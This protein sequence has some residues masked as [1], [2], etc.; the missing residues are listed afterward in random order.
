MGFLLFTKTEVSHSRIGIPVWKIS[1]VESIGKTFKRWNMNKDE[2]SSVRHDSRLDDDG[3]FLCRLVKLLSSH[4][5]KLIL[6]LDLIC[7]VQSP[8][9]LMVWLVSGLKLKPKVALM[10]MSLEKSLST[11]GYL[12]S[13]V[14]S[15]WL[16]CWLVEVREWLGFGITKYP[17]VEK[18]LIL[19]EL[20]LSALG[21]NKIC[22]E[23][24]HSDW[25]H[26]LQN[27]IRMLNFSVNTLKFVYDIGSWRNFWFVHGLKIRYLRIVHWE[28][29]I[30]IWQYFC[31][32]T[33]SKKRHRT[34]Q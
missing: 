24:F 19:D 10:M 22:T 11:L 33:V 26:D 34:W 20:V 28:V 13:P 25:S 21:M 30:K 9:R 12:A 1:K 23:M 29:W 17:Y 7:P 5:F 31:I 18:N 6:Y 15:I 4:D 27:P 14:L 32:F 2:K 3:L 16:L 8:I